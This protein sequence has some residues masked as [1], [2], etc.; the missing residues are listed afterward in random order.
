V[1]L[2]KPGAPDSG[3]P[4]FHRVV[5]NDKIQGP[6]LAR[7]ATKGVTSPLVYYVDDQSPYGEGLRDNAVPTL[8]KLG[9]IAGK[10]SLLPTAGTDYSAISS[11]VKAS[12]ANVVVYFG[13]DLDAGNF[14]KS[15][16]DNGYT[17]IFASGDGAATSTFP[18]TA[19]KKAAE[20]ARITQGDL[21][22]DNIATPAQKAAFTKASGVKV[23]G[24]Y[25]TNTINATNV[26][27]TCIKQGKLTRPA[28][29]TCVT[30]GKFPNFTGYADIKFSRYGDNLSPAPI[31]AYYVVDGEIVYKEEA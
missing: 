23:A 25:V 9:T 1:T 16:R 12:K 26:F 5:P 3:F 15:L 20:G 7:L 6:A 27:L 17:G 18:E 11:K 4:I 28:I 10:D 31:G 21:P 29:Q 22:F 24:G 13:Y 2:T 19:G 14:V 30:N 8:K